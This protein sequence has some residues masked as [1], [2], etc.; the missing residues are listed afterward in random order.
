MGLAADI[1]LRGIVLGVKGIKVLLQPLVS[2]DTGVEVIPS[3][4]NTDRVF[5]YTQVRMGPSIRGLLK[6]RVTTLLKAY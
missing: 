3:P 5:R 4:I 2:R 6:G 1:G